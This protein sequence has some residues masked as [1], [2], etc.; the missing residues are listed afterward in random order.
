M[1]REAERLAQAKDPRI[2]DFVLNQGSFS[3]SVSASGGT[4][5]G[6]GAF[7]LSTRGYT[8]EQ[9]DLIGLLLRTVGFASWRRSP[10]QGDWG[11][12]WHGIARGTEGLPRNARNQVQNYL[13]G[14]TGLRGGGLDHQQ[15]PAQDLTWEQYQAAHGVLTTDVSETT[16]PSVEPATDSDHDGLTDVFEE[17]A[18]TDKKSI[19]T[20]DDGLSDTYEAVTSHTDPLS[21]DTD[22]DGQS[23]PSELAG[24]H[25]AGR[26]PGVAGVVGTGVFAENIRTAKDADEDG[27]SDHLEE[28]VGTNSGES[29]TDHDQIDDATEATLGTDPTL[30]DSDY[31]GITDGL[32]VNS[33]RDPLSANLD[34]TG[35]SVPTAR[36]TPEA[37]YQRRQ[38]TQQVPGTEN[39]GQGPPNA[40]APGQNGQS[41]PAD[42]TAEPPVIQTSGGI[43]AGN[44]GGMKLSGSM[45]TVASQIV[46]T[47]NDVAREEGWDENQRQRAAIIAVATAM[48][49]STLG[50]NPRTNRPNQDQDAGVF[51]Q[52]IK[53]GWYGTLE[54]VSDVR[55]GTRAFLLGH[56]VPKTIE[57]GAGHA[58]YHIP[59]LA[60]IDDWEKLSYSAA[61]HAVQRSAYP[62]IPADFIRMAESVTEAVPVDS[63]TTPQATPI[64]LPGAEDVDL[65][66]DRDGLTNAF[67]ELAGT[68]SKSRDSDQDGMDD[69]YEALTSHTDPR[70][71]DSNRDGLTDTAAVAHGTEVG[72][73]PGVAGV[74]GTGIFAENARDGVKDAD[75]DGLTDHAEELLRTDVGKSDTDGDQLDDATEVTLGTDARMGDTDGDGILDGIE[76]RFHQNPLV[77]ESVLAPGSDGSPNSVPGD[78][79]G[80]WTT[81]EGT[82]VDP[83]DDSTEAHAIGELF[84]S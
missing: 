18:G 2:H 34:A 51:Q 58:G 14:K 22:L 57:G 68:D 60:Q 33:A 29:D 19:D 56:T 4:H 63:G 36:W 30:A 12:H 59:G 32:E 54:Q 64:G 50:D 75:S 80:Q 77:P 39:D 62:E 13:D 8:E 52:R 17:L 49:E 45:A 46:A 15:R 10:S 40:D 84:H 65:D 25:D 7:D 61:S 1:L 20:D 78:Q 79:V 72:R 83:A 74:I 44:Y 24:G 41:V 26:L 21:A 71:A 35:R 70:G 47:T 37:A 82:P 48:K 16:T 55:Y 69:G 42:S 5:S 73:L 67:E 23:D 28:L 76:V 11:E 66:D 27:L 6:P 43:D 53:P 9:K 31:D 81:P 38:A 3:N